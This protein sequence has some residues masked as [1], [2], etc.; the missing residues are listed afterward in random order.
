MGEAAPGAPLPFGGVLSLERFPPMSSGRASSGSESVLDQTP[1]PPS[2]EYVVQNPESVP[3]TAHPRCTRCTPLHP[4]RHTTELLRTPP[5]AAN[6][7][8]TKLR[9]TPSRE[10]VV[11]KP[12]I[13]AARCTPPLH[14]KHPAVP[15]TAE[16]SHTHR[17]TAELSRTHRLTTGLSRTHRHTTG[18]SPRENLVSGCWFSRGWTGL[19]GLDWF[20]RLGPGAPSPFQR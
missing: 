8:S 2:R 11:Q 16:L 10:Y 12:R 7:C 14:M 1:G 15:D 5:W 6:P 20:R 18:F 19:G 13:R 17:H 9:G 3:H 4:H